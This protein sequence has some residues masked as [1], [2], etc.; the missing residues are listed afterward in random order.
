MLKFQ[1]MIVVLGFA[2]LLSGCAGCSSVPEP[3]FLA[4]A[5]IGNKE[6]REANKMK[7]KIISEES[8]GSGWNYLGYYFNKNSFVPAINRS[9]IAYAMQ[10][11]NWC[12]SFDHENYQAYWGAGV[13]RGVQATFT[14]DPLL[15]E[16]YLK[17][18]A[19]F[20]LMAMKHN[21]PANQVNNLNLDLANA[22][23]GLG[24]FYLQSSKKELDVY[25][26]A[27][28]FYAQSSKKELAD[29]Y[30]ASAREILLDVIKKEP[31]NG[32]AFFL[33]AA[34]SFYQGKYAE[35]KQLAEQSQS[36][37]YKVPDDFLKDIANKIAGSAQSR[38]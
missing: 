17:Q 28:A 23:N 11:F 21:V 16:K 13:V 33:L 6:Y 18:S 26:G 20:M 14:D 19:D 30:L 3:A 12:W 4:D 25:R 5:P 27:N 7:H 2:L 37:H 36:K 24:A 8:A 9:Y 10:N 32:R 38:K 29:A 31:E 22:Y 1:N 15:A 35:A 34:T